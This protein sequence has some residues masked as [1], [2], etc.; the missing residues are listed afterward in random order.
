MEG[1]RRSCNMDNPGIYKGFRG[2][3]TG[4]SN[5]ILVAASKMETSSKRRTPAEP[6]ATFCL[7][8]I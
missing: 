6:T 5:T 1:E 8:K 4:R 2:F 7:A 3:D